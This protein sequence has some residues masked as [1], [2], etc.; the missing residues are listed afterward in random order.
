MII[1]NVEAAD[2]NEVETV[3]ELTY[4]PEVG[5][6]VLLD[7]QCYEIRRRLFL[8]DKDVWIDAKRYTEISGKLSFA[9]KLVSP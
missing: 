1:F 5:D 3:G 7:E 2:R 9:P 6:F 8:S 4:L